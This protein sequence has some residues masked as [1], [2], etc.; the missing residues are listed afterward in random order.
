MT[1]P[2]AVRAMLGARSVAVVGASS[3]PGSFGERL[4]TEVL[5]SPS[6]PEVT[7]VNPRY[8]VVAGRPCVPSLRDLAAPVDLVLLAVNDTVVEQQLSLSAER[9][10]RSAVVFGS[11]WSPPAPGPSL[12]QRVTAVAEGAG[13]ALCGGGCMGFVQV[14]GGLRALG[15]LERADLP[16]GPVALVSHS[17]SAFSALLRTR[18]RIGWASAVS[19]G[20][21]LVTTTADYL[22]H[23]LDQ[24]GTRVVALVLETLRATDRLR[25]AL[26]RAAAQDVPV[27]LLAVGGTPAASALVTAHSGALAGPDAVWE[28]LTDAHGLL[29]VAD[30][31]EMV[32][33]LELLTAGRRAVGHGPGTGLATVHDS[34]AERVL[35]AD[36]AH[37]AGVPFAPLSSTTTKRLESLL[38][39]GLEVGNPLDVWGT[40]AETRGLFAGALCALADDPAVA[41]VALAVD[42]VEEFDGDDSYPRA[43]LDALG[44][45]DKPVVV[46]ANV[47]SAVD[48]AWAARLR[49][50]GA[51]VLEG[52]SSGLRALGHLL[53]LAGPG[54]PPV[55]AAVDAG[56]RD[57]WL[58][59]LGT[60][61]L[62]QVESFALLRDY[63][64]A[65]VDVQ[66]ASTAAEAVAAADQVGYPAVLKTDEQVAHKSDVGGVVLGLPDGAA[67]ASAYQ[68]MCDRLGPRVVLCSTAG[69]GVELSLGLTRD[70]L[71]G[72][73]VVVGAGGLLVE[74]LADR[75]VGLPPL[76]EW[77]ATLLVDRLRLRPVLDGVRGRPAVDVAAVVRA[78]VAMSGIATELG[79]AV[80][81]LD[82][83]PL[84]AT[85]RGVVAADVLVVAG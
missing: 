64:I 55:S 37:R 83:N 65:T 3:R 6:A 70:P 68:E 51:P 78:A 52:T 63:G 80:V 11:V 9:G 74:V 21:E 8:D 26:D 15:Y 85:P 49:E 12:R 59:R 23:A 22:E 46:L 30:L 34:G 19:S 38:D 77:R 25:A 5:R 44:A 16:A 75:A 82:V 66:A 53:A 20:Q 18:R 17:G 47:V 4:V 71:V 31:D 13:M 42:L 41:A 79:D 45:T 1:S 60:G 58:A 57:R 33:L 56:R 7:L 62:D 43:V 54:L 69:P 61:P 40:G 76:D 36:I 48:Q 28:A 27:V 24:R 39:P 32:D 29:R 72:V 73:L 81:G 84:V 14:A 2:D 35:V 10:D 67:V 50:A